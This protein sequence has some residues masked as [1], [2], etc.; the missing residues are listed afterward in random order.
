M[1]KKVSKNYIYNLLYQMTVVLVP[2]LTTPY[3]SRALHSQG[4]GIYSYT[5]AI[6]TGF[7]LFAALGIKNYGQREIAYCQEDCHKRSVIFWELVLLRG[8]ISFAVIAVYLLF[9]FWYKEYT[10]NLLQQTFII[11]AVIFDLSWFFQGIEEFKIVAMR[12]IVVKVVM[13]ILIFTVVNDESDLGIYILI[14]SVTM[15]V[16]NLIFWSQI[17]KHVI[18]ILWKELH[19]MRHIRGTLEFFVPLIAVQIYSQLDKIMLGAL[20]NSPD[21]NGYYE[22]SRK[23]INVANSILISL[24]TV[25]LPRISNLYINNDKNKILKIYK[26]ATNVLFFLMIPMMVGMI[27]ISDNLVIWFLGVEFT[28]VAFLLKIST[29]LLLFMGLGNFVGT[30]Y[31]I[32]TGKQNIMTLVYIVAALV[33]IV[34]N[35]LLIPKFYAV[36]ALVASCIA[37]SISCFSQVLLLKKGELNFDILKG[38]WK[39]LI[40]AV[41]MGIGLFILDKYTSMQGMVYTIVQVVV[42]VVIYLI[43]QILLKTEEIQKV[44]KLIIK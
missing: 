10:I 24:N 19:I 23:I 11:V 28:E 21:E 17:R 36:G 38:V 41:I 13:V 35:F 15:L 31:L 4:V 30:Q 39:Y 37:E 5:N 25:L 42:G 32:P 9:C 14:N 29:P 44:K 16:S 20:V 34:L 3:I 40:S 27:V 2:I 43:M 7:S 8:I 12:N 1:D 33:N 22:Q 26:E 18:M 6:A